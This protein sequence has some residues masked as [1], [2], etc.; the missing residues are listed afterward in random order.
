MTTAAFL[1]DLERRGVSL[2]ASGD[3]LSLRAPRGV[4]TEAD[5]D[6]LRAE[7]P[8][9]LALL[10]GEDATP[11]APFPL[12][13][14]QQA[15]LVGRSAE[16]ELGRVGCHAYREFEAADLDL[17]RLEAAWNRLVARHPMLRAV[18]TP[19][20]LQRVLPD[21]PPCRIE[22][23]DLRQAPDPGAALAAEREARSHH[24]FDPAQ[25]PLFSLMAALLPDGRVRL[26]VGIDLLVADAA[27]LVT[28]FRDWGAL[29]AAPERDLPPLPA[30]FADHARRLPQPTDRDRAYWQAR[31][32]D[33]PPGPDLPLQP[34]A[35][36]PRFTRRTHRI[37]APDWQALRAAAA[38]RGIT[39]SILL[40]TAL[41]DILAGWSR[42]ARFAVTLTQFAAPPGMEGVVGDFTS[43]ILL[44]AD[45]TPRRFEDRA[46]ALQARLA[47]DL[48]HASMSGV[49]VLREIRRLRPEAAAVP[50]VFT[51]TIGH[52]SLGGGTS[53][54]A[55]LGETVFAVTQTPQ[56][57][58]DHHV[59]EEAGA[60]ILGWDAVE[61]AFPPGV[62]DAMVGAHADLLSALLTE[63]GWDRDAS[64]CRPAQPRA[65]LRPAATPR[66]L[67]AA[68]EEAARAMP[69]RP[70]VIDG[71]VTL[72]HA[73]LHAAAGHLAARLHARLGEKTRDR[74]VA[75][76]LPKGWRQIVAVLAVLKAGAAY[77]PVD[78]ALPAERRRHLIAQGEALPLDDAAEIDTALAAARQGPPPALPAVEDPSRLAYVI[79]TSG[80]TGQP[81]GVMIEHQAAIATVAE[82]NRRW[83]IGA[84]DRAF[85]LS[86]L[87][88]DLSVWDIFG[89]LAEGGALV[90]PPPDAARDPAAWSA[91]LARHRVTVWNSV[92]AL[93]AM[94]ME[95]GLPPGHA[96]RL[97]M[98]SGDWVPIE[99]VR[100][101]RDAMPGTALVAL[102]GA[103]E[104]AI[105]SN[106]H[107]VA[108][109][110]PAWPSIPYGLPL[111]GQVLHVVD[112]RGAP[113]PDWVT[114][115]I[116]IAGAGL[117]RGYW[118]DPVRTAERFVTNPFTGERRY[119]TGDLGRFRRHGDGAGPTPIEFL[120][121]EDFQVKIQGYRIELGEIEAALETH[122][123]VAAACATVVDGPGGKAL[124]AFVAP[125]RESWERARRVLSRPGLRRGDAPRIPLPH[126]PDAASYDAR[127][128]VRRFTDAALP[129]AAVDALLAAAGMPVTL[130]PRRVEGTPPAAWPRIEIPDPATARVAEAAAALLLLEAPHGRGA[131]LAAGQA[132]Q[133]MMVA[134]EAL[135]LGLCAIGLLRRD[136]AP[137]LHAFACGIPATEVSG[138]DLA[139]AL[140]EH[141]AAVLPAYMVPRHL[142]ML[143]ALPLS[144][145]GKVDR[146]ALKPPAS[147][148]AAPAG[149]LEAG[150]AALVAEALGQPVHPQRNLF[151][152]GATSLHMVRL[153]R[154]LA[155]RMGSRLTVVDLFRLPSISALA[156]AL[157]GDA[158]EG[159][160]Q[161][162]L[163]RAAR[164]RAAQRR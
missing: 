47:A 59:F 131:L 57:V 56:V 103:T 118:R 18:V 106:A 73:T 150:V 66:L 22:R 164:R 143:E 142:H 104:A 54:L 17:D 2:S 92:P 53:P 1:Q 38:A 12:T 110:D 62:L 116:E 83:A 43:T 36:P 25:W 86:A 105:W 20:G 145:N 149:G 135:G 45:V 120:G 107:E 128:S 153:Q 129:R 70:A 140:R 33:F 3:E 48:D 125:R 16:L 82:I 71:D 63:A 31:L 117:A 50:V 160:V 72:D 88:F 122:P 157:A 29:Y 68:L 75:I 93:M 130:L 85:G 146:S 37:P 162:G 112:A 133:R 7:K 13:E 4:L 11:D 39:A 34:L 60:L 95:H 111:A 81:K 64:A 158:A 67:H 102:G 161:G 96:L 26:G 148:A 61:A 8:A 123:E 69:D 156:A 121:R 49:A 137:V 84:E 9:I 126:R 113:C 76:V 55:W 154:L 141:C 42:R 51:S 97:V 19:D 74:L 23:I 32:A 127:R 108:S 90:L 109:L 28:L 155:D 115:E 21:V 77:L 15:Y 79:Y 52:P 24:V 136:G 6:R 100:R 114:G 124:H 65:A 132:G 144:G 46:R 35:G 151:D 44:E 89:P 152:A 10:R 99:L 78:P 41:A 138:V 139:G 87:G 58:L 163:D 5:R 98:M 80:S 27:A 94:Q 14:I 30:R 101:L 40:A 147:D 159:A 134:A 91:L 119:R